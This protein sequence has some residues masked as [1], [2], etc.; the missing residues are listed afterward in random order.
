MASLGSPRPGD[1]NNHLVIIFS[2]PGALI[3]HILTCVFMFLVLPPPPST[4]TIVVF[5][6]SPGP[7]DPKNHLK[8]IYFTLGA[9][10]ESLGDINGTDFDILCFRPTHPPPPN[11]PIWLPTAPGSPQKCAA[12]REGFDPTWVRPYSLSSD[13]WSAI[14]RVGPCMLKISPDPGG[15]GRR[16]P[17]LGHGPGGVVGCLGWSWFVLGWSCS[18]QGRVLGPSWDRL[19]PSRGGSR[20]TRAVLVASWGVSG[21]VIV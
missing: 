13:R 17:G 9:L 20:V 3:G 5:C 11:H 16:S 2:T 21:H 14:F 4:P 1:P 15:R 6:G 12:H 18:R 10:N 7:G 8:H 19:G